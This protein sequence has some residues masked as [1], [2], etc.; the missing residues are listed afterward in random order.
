MVF[1]DDAFRKIDGRLYTKN[2]VPGNKVYGERLHTIDGTEYREWSPFRSKLSAYLSTGG[3]DV[4]FT[5]TSNVLYLG[6]ASGTTASHISDIVPKGMLYCV[7]FSPR[8]FRD[9]VKVCDI[10]KNMTPILADATNPSEYSF[11]VPAVDIVYQDVA[12][13]RQ[14]E[15]LVDN[16][17]TFSARYGMIAIKARSEDVTANPETIFRNAEKS[18]K[19]KGF[20]IIDKRL[21]DPF[22]KDHMMIVTERSE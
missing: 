21:L 11:A 9:L 13:K 17:N 2:S 4:P 19:E 12:Q 6:A 14:I 22:E 7:E 5:E 15:I 16:M 18:L 1:P 8:T 20:K 3:T 10:R